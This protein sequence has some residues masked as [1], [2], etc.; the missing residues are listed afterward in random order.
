MLSDPADLAFE[1]SAF[2][3][4]RQET[5]AGCLATALVEL[6]LYRADDT[7]EAQVERPGES[8]GHHATE[9]RHCLALGLDPEFGD[10]RG[11]NEDALS[12][13]ITRLRRAR[14]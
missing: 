7:L 13:K 10:L 5:A 12:G 1:G 14:K 3:M 6:A 11:M 8:E 2:T 4:D 9:V